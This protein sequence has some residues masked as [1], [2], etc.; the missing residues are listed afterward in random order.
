MKKEARENMSH[1]DDGTLH[2]YL[3]G[4]LSPVEL[5]QLEA[6]LASCPA[7]RGRLDEE[8]GLIERA[9]ALLAAALPPERA[10]P[11]FQGLRPASPLRRYRLPL[12]WA[13][14]ILLAVGG[15]WYLGLNQIRREAPA[16][17]DGLVA[18][19]LDSIP[20][21]TSLAIREPASRRPAGREAVRQQAPADS[22]P[23]V[24]LP[25]PLAPTVVSAGPPAELKASDAP[26]AAAANVVVVDRALRRAPVVLTT[27]WQIIGLDAARPTLGSDAVTIPG[28][29]VRDVRRSPLGDG[30]V[31]VEQ[32]LD[33]TTVIQLFQRRADQVTV[34]GQLVATGVAG[35]VT[36]R[37]RA[38]TPA[39]APSPSAAREAV[40]GAERLARYIG[41]LRVEIAGPLTTDS[42]SKLLDLVK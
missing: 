12:A 35:G 28:V 17:A 21:P 22:A 1:A 39:A 27:T 32:S 40:K 38:A 5:A 11:P 23:A 36:E 41:G 14:T 24:P 3:D 10:L 25:L 42:L 13:A 2:A 4:Q 33:S 19:R 29:P 7:C 30:V 15:G 18:S 26:M 31:V 6:H 16:A 37:G 8:R 34:D 9:D 20:P